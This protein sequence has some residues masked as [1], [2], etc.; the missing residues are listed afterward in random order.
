LSSPSASVAIT[1]RRSVSDENGMTDASA[2]RRTKK[3]APSPAITAIRRWRC[4]G[5]EEER[6]TTS[7]CID[8][9]C[10]NFAWR[11]ALKLVRRALS[12]H[13]Y[14]ASLPFL[15]DCPGIVVYQAAG[16][17]EFDN[18]Q[19]IRSSLP[20]MVT[21]PAGM[22]VVPPLRFGAWQGADR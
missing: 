1:F 18:H 14:S 6:G 12:F 7:D 20:N 4:E 9:L 17:T 21:G 10:I 15:R 3:N 11:I 8:C 22:H 16:R 13:L 2:T 5:R 19:R